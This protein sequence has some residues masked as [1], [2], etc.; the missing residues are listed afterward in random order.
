LKE[1]RF[2]IGKKFDLNELLKG[3]LGLFKG[4]E[5]FEVVVDLDAFAADDVRGGGCIRARS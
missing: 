4:Q 2:E 3:S 5:D 1:G